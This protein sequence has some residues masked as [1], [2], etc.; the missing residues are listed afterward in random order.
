ML[1]CG[2]P[3]FE[4]VLMAVIVSLDLVSTASRGNSRAQME[5]DSASCSFD[6]GI[7]DGFIQ[8][9]NY[10]WKAQTTP[11]TEGV[12]PQAGAGYVFVDRQQ[13]QSNAGR[14]A[15][16]RTGP[17]TPA[18]TSPTD[19]ITVEFYY[20]LGPGTTK[21]E[22]LVHLAGL[23]SAPLSV[24][25]QL[26]RTVDS[27]QASEQVWLKVSQQFCLPFGLPISKELVFRVTPLTGFT[28]AA[29]D[30]LT[31]FA[32]SELPS[33]TFTCN[34]PPAVLSCGFEDDACSAAAWVNDDNDQLNWL[35]V[36]RTATEAHGGTFYL[37][38]EKF[39]SSSLGAVA[40]VVSRQIID[41]TPLTYLFSFYYRRRITQ[42]SL[43][44]SV[45]RA[46]APETWIWSDE[47]NV[48]LNQWNK[49]EVLLCGLNHFQMAF[50]TNREDVSLDDISLS[51]TI[52]DNTPL[53]CLP[54]TTATCDFE[55]KTLCGWT[56]NSE[57][58][59]R[60][61]LTTGFIGGEVLG[62]P[63]GAGQ[64]IGFVH[65][66]ANDRFTGS[67]QPARLQS[68]SPIQLNRA[69]TFSFWYH[70]RGY[71]IR[72]LQLEIIRTTPILNELLWKQDGGSELGW[73]QATVSLC[74]TT[75]IKLSFSASFS[76]PDHVIGLDSFVLAD[77]DTVSGT[78]PPAGFQCPEDTV[79]HLTCD[80]D[81]DGIC[82]WTNE[83]PNFSWNV[84]DINAPPPPLNPLDDIIDGNSGTKILAARSR[85]RPVGSGT[86]MAR[87]VSRPLVGTV[88]RNTQLEFWYNM[89]G[90][91]SSLR[92]LVRESG[93][94]QTVWEQTGNKGMAWIK[95]AFTICAAEGSEVIFEAQFTI[96]ELRSIGL[97]SIVYHGETAATVTI[98][99]QCPIVSCNFESGNCGWRHAAPDFAWSNQ[100]NLFTPDGGHVLT[101]FFEG[102]DK[103][104]ATTGCLS[105]REPTEL[106]FW[107]FTSS[108]TQ[109]K[110]TI[111]T[112][113]HPPPQS[114]AVVQWTS[115]EDDTALEWKLQTVDIPA[116]L[117][118]RLIL[119][120]V[121][122]NGRPQSA[123]VDALIL[124]N[125]AELLTSCDP[126][127]ATTPPPTIPPTADVTGNLSCDFENAS[128]CGWNVAGSPW[129]LAD[130]P[131]GTPPYDLPDASSG[132][133]L[134]YVDSNSLSVVNEL[135]AL[136][137]R[138]HA[139]VK[140]KL[141]FSY[142]SYGFGVGSLVLYAQKNGVRYLLWASHS[143]PRT[144]ATA[145]VDICLS[146]SY[147]F[148]F[149]ARFLARG[150]VVGLDNIILESEV[151][152]V[153]VPVTD[154]PILVPFITPAPP[155]TLPPPTIQPTTP[156]V[157][158][159]PVT[160][161]APTSA[162]T[163]T[164]ITL[165]SI[166]RGD[167]SCDFEGENLCNWRNLDLHQGNEL[168]WRPT[169]SFAATGNISASA[170]SNFV[171][172]SAL[173]GGARYVA[174]LISPHI[175]D[176]IGQERIRFQ[177][178]YR[179]SGRG[180]SGVTVYLVNS[181]ALPSAAS[182]SV[183]IGALDQWNLAK[184][185]IP[186]PFTPRRQVFLQTSFIR[187][188]SWL[189]IDEI[190]LEDE[191]ERTTQAVIVRPT[192]PV[193]EASTA[194]PSTIAPQDVTAPTTVAAGTGPTTTPAGFALT[195]A[196]A[197]KPLETFS[198]MQADT[199]IGLG[200][201]CGVLGVIAVGVLLY[202]LSYKRGVQKKAR[203]D[204]VEGQ[205]ELALQATSSR[206]GTD[207]N[208]KV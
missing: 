53:N 199:V 135:A 103:A 185:D 109:A 179:A 13:V 40:T 129:L 119:E 25:F 190:Q 154:C 114:P 178:Y 54:I 22:L 92:V 42:S 29:L 24:P 70:T 18:A 95:A 147:T 128:A 126:I 186:S 52:P 77:E 205:K 172:V 198:K 171:Q 72:Q 2:M 203:R 168:F 20:R 97:D 84:E 138:L 36:S 173:E 56:T 145:M 90:S 116:S 51:T 112:Q 157:T 6:S 45:R 202:H 123:S 169:K 167:F 67:S 136:E 200:A 148:I 153:S 14:F 33:P 32:E 87:L 16:L 82:G 158:A 96:P 78:L 132:R 189:A 107:Y 177:F 197:S 113:N 46:D 47:S 208:T 73:Q 15:E 139:P 188:D 207:L 122:L 176:T 102:T 62:Q 118:F 89:K 124:V 206:V 65:A 141:T 125:E 81:S 94:S 91:G 115:D 28:F 48:N 101:A 181:E 111:S 93:L 43:A 194:A 64:G 60:F 184:V 201:G 74:S 204:H 165:P 57:S 183:G 144:W 5:L 17:L 79:R 164:P 23:P 137:S 162:P 75:E 195:T 130:P 159:P 44:L 19:L 34:V 99:G 150:F 39:A 106:T 166:H 59:F 133:G 149:E 37:R 41:A 131:V 127:P 7:C 49:G 80:F 11:V 61:K 55:G 161:A 105:L 192:N 9:G 68:I 76:F 196:T 3:Q 27:A 4:A 8:R 180:A 163:V 98:P 31:T 134:V 26:T 1:T 143:S 12:D 191:Y 58:E 146:D 100:P 140:S 66:A 193:P 38:S 50:S 142:R 174:R 155:T 182:W 120:G 88:P 104:R 30:E 83:T 71:G 156:Q 121:S 187:D 35:R 110:V 117:Q 69:T 152:G 108:E 170:G 85:N 10:A 63:V 160:T 86:S 175:R 151:S 21:V